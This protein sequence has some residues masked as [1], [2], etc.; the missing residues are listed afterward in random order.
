MHGGVGLKV[1]ARLC[2]WHL[3]AGGE[4]L[5]AVVAEHLQVCVHLCD[6]SRHEAPTDR[7]SV[8]SEGHFAAEVMRKTQALRYLLILI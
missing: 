2:L 3:G 1:R 6:V 5:L 4:S 8:Q 7:A